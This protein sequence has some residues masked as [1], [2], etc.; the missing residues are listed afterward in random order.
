MV[1]NYFTLPRKLAISFANIYLGV[2]NFH[3]KTKKEN[4]NLNG[5]MDGWIII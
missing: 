5:W 4:G 1:P 2:E 3:K